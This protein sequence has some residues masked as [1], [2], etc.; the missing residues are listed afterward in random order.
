MNKEEL[1]RK[2]ELSEYRDNITI[3]DLDFLELKDSKNTLFLK[4]FLVPDENDDY[5]YIEKAF[6]V[7]GRFIKNPGTK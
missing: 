7:I 2:I 6:D 4:I 3:N 5:S 1:L